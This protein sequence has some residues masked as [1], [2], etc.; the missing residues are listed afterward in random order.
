M[1]QNPFSRCTS[2]SSDSLFKRQSLRFTEGKTVG[3]SLGSQ[4]ATAAYPS[5]WRES[6]QVIFG[7]PIASWNVIISLPSLKPEFP[8]STSFFAQNIY[9][10]RRLVSTQNP[11]GAQKTVEESVKLLMKARRGGTERFST[12]LDAEKTGF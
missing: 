5:P 11:T 3:V 12:E 4:I 7:G 2:F 6:I 1:L 8:L 9:V 10:R